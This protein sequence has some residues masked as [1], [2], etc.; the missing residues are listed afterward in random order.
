MTRRALHLPVPGQPTVTAGTALSSGDLFSYLLLARFFPL[1][2]YSVLN[3]IG[4]V[5]RLPVSTFFATLVIGSFPFNLATV[6][7]GDVV[8]AVIASGST[9]TTD[10]L[11]NIWRPEVIQ[12]LVL[13]TVVSVLPLIFKRQLQRALSGGGALATAAGAIRSI[14]PLL[15]RTAAALREE[16]VVEAAKGVP[17]QLAFLW[18]RLTGAV[19]RRAFGFS[20]VSASSSS[21]GAATSS[22]RW[23]SSGR[24]AYNPVPSFA[25]D[26]FS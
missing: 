25:E 3:V 26:D 4:G 14:P 11:S 6:S 1:L 12:K 23:S 21:T 13:A 17:T 24:N 10:A 19:T 20:S 2:P 9:S 18:T 5:L 16:G 7:I 15:A 8:A 22:G